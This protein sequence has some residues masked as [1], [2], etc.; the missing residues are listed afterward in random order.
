MEY[1]GGMGD[2]R[3]RV[4]KIVQWDLAYVG[5]RAWEIMMLIISMC[6]GFFWCMIRVVAMSGRR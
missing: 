6:K 4:S 3:C 5:C 1:F 2:G